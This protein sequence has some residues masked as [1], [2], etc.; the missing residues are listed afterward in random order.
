MITCIALH[1]EARGVEVLVQDFF[2]ILSASTCVCVCVILFI[3]CLFFFWGGGGGG[4]G[5]GGLCVWEN[6]FQPFPRK[7]RPTLWRVKTQMLDQIFSSESHGFH[8]FLQHAFFAY[9]QA[10][11]WQSSVSAGFSRFWLCNVP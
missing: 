9:V 3:F 10:E 2:L 5:G 11:F 1:T 8:F 7:D 4:C 6:I